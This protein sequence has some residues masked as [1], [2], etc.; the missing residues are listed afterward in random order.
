MD[1]DGSGVARLGLG[2]SST[3]RR[4]VSGAL[5]ATKLSYR[6]R[7]EDIVSIKPSQLDTPDISILRATVLDNIILL[8]WPNTTR[9]GLTEHGLSLRT[10]LPKLS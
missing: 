3:A 7:L 2:C 8:S 9:N 6:Y 1:I 4:E 5:K 10:W